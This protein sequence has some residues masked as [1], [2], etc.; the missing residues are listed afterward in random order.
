MLYYD[1]DV[2]AEMLV[3]YHCVIGTVKI[4]GSSLGTSSDCFLIFNECREYIN[5]IPDKI[6]LITS[7][8]RF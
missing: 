2:G 4:H 7:Q 5:M 8:Y 1:S 6:A 3:T